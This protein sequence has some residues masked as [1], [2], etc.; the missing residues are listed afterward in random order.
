MELSKGEI[1]NLFENID[2]NKF[3]LKKITILSNE[4]FN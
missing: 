1:E 3:M 4:R 2:E